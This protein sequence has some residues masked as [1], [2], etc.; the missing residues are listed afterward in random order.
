MSAE[1]K[2]RVADCLDSIRVLLLLKNKA[3]STNNAR[4][5]DWHSS[6]GPLTVGA[7]VVSMDNIHGDDDDDYD[8]NSIIIPAGMS[9][10]RGAT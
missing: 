7:A 10:K 6:A 2:L 8:E 3:T 5:A 9:T 1:Q 4:A